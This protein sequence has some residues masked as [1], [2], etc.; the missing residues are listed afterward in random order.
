MTYFA[1]LESKV[2]SLTTALQD[3]Q[4][5]QEQILEMKIDA[6]DQRR[7]LEHDLSQ[8]RTVTTAE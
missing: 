1:H 8:A 7:K 5:L 2:A 3:K 6:R 4:L